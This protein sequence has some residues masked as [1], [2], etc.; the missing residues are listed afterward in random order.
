MLKGHV[1]KSGEEIRY[2]LL[3]DNLNNL[4]DEVIEFGKDNLEDVG[5]LKAITGKNGIEY[6]DMK[7]M[8]MYFW[9]IGYLQEI[10]RG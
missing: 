2:I 1:S 10:N 7:L 4:V 6:T 8:D 5:R 3:G 9:Q